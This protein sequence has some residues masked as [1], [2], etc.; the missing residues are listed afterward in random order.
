M[1]TFASIRG[2]D[3]PHLVPTSFAPSNELS[4][5][6]VLLL[7]IVTFPYNFNG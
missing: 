7:I 2:E 5:R 1:L 4:K 3:L 6:S